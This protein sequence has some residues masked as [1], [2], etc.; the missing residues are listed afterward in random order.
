MFDCDNKD[1]FTGFQLKDV[2]NKCDTFDEI[3]TSLQ[4]FVDLGKKS[5]S[6]SPKSQ[7]ETRNSE[8]R[9]I[10]DSDDETEE[11]EEPAP[12]PSYS[13]EKLF[14]ELKID[15][16]KLK[17]LREEHDIDDKLFWEIEHAKLMEF[18]DI[19]KWGT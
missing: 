7:A 5:V 14:K 19:K 2:V 12:T 15:D 13:I 6:A 4:Q 18:L 3:K 17:T 9:P 10:D 16:D 8:T 1:V 11:K